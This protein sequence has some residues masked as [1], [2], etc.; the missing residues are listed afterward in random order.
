MDG[1]QEGGVTA[2]DEEPLTP[3]QQA[4]LDMSEEIYKLKENDKA[5]DAAIKTL[6]RDIATLMRTKR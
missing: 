6:A 3:E 5:Q 2:P 1:C 4:M